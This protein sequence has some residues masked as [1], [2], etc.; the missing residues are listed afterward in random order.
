MNALHPAPQIHNQPTCH[1]TY[2]W[3]SLV[4]MLENP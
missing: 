4:I 1:S 3:T 2:V